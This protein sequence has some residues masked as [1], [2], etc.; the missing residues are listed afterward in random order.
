MD[1]LCSLDKA[2]GIAAH[3]TGTSSLYTWLI[4][5][6]ST[7]CVLISLAAISTQFAIPRIRDLGMRG[8]PV[9]ALIASCGLSAALLFASNHFDELAS[10]SVVMTLIP[11]IFFCIAAWVTI[12]DTTV[13][14]VLVAGTRSTL[15]FLA[16]Y[17]IV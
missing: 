1:L 8:T 2:P 4:V 5:A 9:Y 7:S 16:I 6:V 14:I 17:F 15:A 11:Y 12:W 10:M 13:R 3:L